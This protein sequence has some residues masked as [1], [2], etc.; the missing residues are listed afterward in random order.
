MKNFLFRNNPLE[1]E[2]PIDDLPPDDNG[3]L[4]LLVKIIPSEPNLT[5]LYKTVVRFDALTKQDFHFWQ[6]K[7]LLEWWNKKT[8]HHSSDF[9]HPTRST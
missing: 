9:T 3:I 6:T 5:V 1:R 8:A 7:E 4:P 2:A